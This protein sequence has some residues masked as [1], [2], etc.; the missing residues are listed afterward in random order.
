MKFEHTRVFNIEGAIRGMRN[1]LNS[2]DKSDS[3]EAAVGTDDDNLAER[4]I[5]SG[6]PH[7]KFLRQIF[8]SVD[9]TAPLYWWSEMDTYKVGTTAD[10]C[11]TMHTIMKRLLSLNDFETESTTPDMKKKLAE[12][13]GTINTM[14]SNNDPSNV[15]ATIQM[16]RYVKMLLPSSFLQKRTWTA[17]YAVLRNIYE[18]RKNHQLPEW[19]ENFCGWIDSLP[20][21]HWIKMGHC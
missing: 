12:I 19:R 4:L 20:Y 11:S 5:K 6:P 18:Y 2:W 1:P 17:D 13:I 9:I 21:N 16:K 8:V 3:T 10:S 14:I 15:E 7:C